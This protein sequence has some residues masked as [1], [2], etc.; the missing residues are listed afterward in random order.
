MHNPKTEA[1]FHFVSAYK[2]PLRMMVF[3]K[4]LKTTQ[5]T[6]SLKCFP[7]ATTPF[8]KTS[9]IWQPLAICDY[10]SLE[11]WLVR[12]EMYSKVILNSGFGRL[13][14]P[15]TVHTP[16]YSSAWHLGASGATAWAGRASLLHLVPCL[17][18][19]RVTKAGSKSAA[20]QVALE[21]RLWTQVIGQFHHLIQLPKDESKAKL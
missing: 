21:S 7:Q 2:F 3:L 11:L 12:T 19:C 5:W 1:S 4:H 20:V 14:H 6:H 18:C 15:H 8:Q 13:P 10:W 9:N 16:S 17:G